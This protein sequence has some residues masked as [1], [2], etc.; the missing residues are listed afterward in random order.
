MGRSA[1]RRRDSQPARIRAALL[2]DEVNPAILKGSNVMAAAS[3]G[4]RHVSKVTLVLIAILVAT[5]WAPAWA[6]APAKTFTVTVEKKRIDIGDG[7][8]YDAWTFN[9]IVQ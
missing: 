9:G 4:P 5:A 6:E 7:M 8:T 1:D 2:Q 3:V